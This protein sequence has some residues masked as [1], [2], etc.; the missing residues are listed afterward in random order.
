M[1]ILDIEKL[2]TGDIILTRSSSGESE[3]IRQL[4]QSDYS[5]AI[6]Y[7]GVSSCIESDGL[8]VQSQNI[9]RMLFENESDVLVLRLKDDNFK[10]LLSGAIVFARQKIGT[11][12]STT[13]ARLARLEK[14]I[15]AKETNRQFCT[16]FV[17]Q[18]YLNSGIQIV[19]NP[20]YC[21]PNDIQ[22]SE[23]LTIINQVLRTASKAE[24]AFAQEESPLEK[25]K[26]IHNFIFENARTISGQDIQTFEQLSKYVL[27]NPEKDNDITNIIEKSGYLEMWKGDVERNSWHYDYKEL[28]KHYTDPR[29]RK[30]V[31]YFFA[32]T[33]RE[34]R[35]RFYQTLDTVEFGYS[36]YGQKY[37]EV[38]IDLYKKLIDLSETREFVGLLALTK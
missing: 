4:S 16:R 23:L 19:S 22:G 29:Q 25:Q 21:S 35:E 34:T 7:V 15:A 13:E 6:I 5:H 9:Q 14:S 33:E 17:A 24:I 28:L 32:T 37:F 8:G 10:H 3:L 12:Y 38:Q 26:E 1:Y 18:A 2:E 31:G 36:F 20:N 11:E 30:E 27:E